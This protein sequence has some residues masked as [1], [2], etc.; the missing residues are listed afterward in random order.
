M[1]NFGGSKMGRGFD[2]K[3][4]WK[5]EKFGYGGKKKGSKRNDKD[6]FENINE[7]REKF[8]GPKGGAD[9]FRGRGRARGGRSR[10]RR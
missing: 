9:G 2:A 4:K 1:K 5:S 8:G 10:G 6:S 7:G 3:K